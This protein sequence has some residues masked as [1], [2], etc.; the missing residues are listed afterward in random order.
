MRK[1]LTE[2]KFKSKD[3]SVRF[4]VIELAESFFRTIV[5]EKINSP[6]ELE[7]SKQITSTNN[8]LQKNLI[9][10]L[11]DESTDVEDFPNQTTSAA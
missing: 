10:K 7:E 8:V 2:H 11:E 5:K 6:F 4:S 9:G 3:T 1:C